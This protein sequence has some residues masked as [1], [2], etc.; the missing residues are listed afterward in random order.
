MVTATVVIGQ[1]YCVLCVEFIVVK[2]KFE[3]L[4]W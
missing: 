1:C 3:I 2:G 4:H